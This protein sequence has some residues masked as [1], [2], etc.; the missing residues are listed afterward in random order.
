M[1][2]QK[3][4]KPEIAAQKKTVKLPP[5]IGDWTTYKPPKVLVKKV[6]TGLYGF[7]RLSKEELNQFLL[8]HYRF[9]ED[10]LKRLKI[11]LRM[12]TEL[13]AVQTEQTIYLNFLRPLTTPLVQ[14]KITLPG[15]H[16]SVHL[17]L[18]LNLANSIINHALGSQDVLETVNRSLTEA[19]ATTL[20]TALEEY[21]SSYTT[22][23]KDIFTQ[24]TIE[25]V[26]SPDATIDPSVN[27]SATIVSFSAELAFGDNPPGRIII[28]YLGSTIKNLLSKYQQK[29]SSSTLDFSK[30][31][32]ELLKKITI[33]ISV[34]L[35]QTT[36]TT[37]EIRSLES[38]D[39]VSIDTLLNSA[40]PLSIGSIIKVSCQPGVNDN[41]LSARISSVKEAKMRIAPPEILTQEKIIE[42]PKVAAEEVIA[43][44]QKPAEKEPVEDD[45]A[46]DDFSDDDFD[47]DDET[48]EEPA[49]PTNNDENNEEFS[50][51]DLNLD[52]D[53]DDDDDF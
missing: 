13:F 23:F 37:G 1:V 44:K 4:G 3:T 12:A 15:I 7:D 48:F 42:P 6:K 25:I 24:P 5:A 52:D 16:E 2:E 10:L 29:T 33:P 9:I 46:D 38:G 36:L 19:E 41:N 26:S 45:F 47:L 18:D 21:F 11:D 30:L 49:N 39:V 27:T 35:G 31:N 43:P 53:D 20:K 22:A 28:G 8:I 34:K 14:I 50:D 40:M 51:D 17:F 32:P